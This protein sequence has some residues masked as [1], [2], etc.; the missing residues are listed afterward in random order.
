MTRFPSPRSWGSAVRVYG[1]VGSPLSWIA[2]SGRMS[3]SSVSMGSLRMI[4]GI[5]AG[6][7]YR[8]RSAETAGDVAHELIRARRALPRASDRMLP[9]GPSLKRSLEL[10][11][12]VRTSSL[13]SQCTLDRF[14]HEQGVMMGQIVPKS[15]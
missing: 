5:D 4:G 14:L 11:Y 10:R 9:V 15:R 12:F 3:A 13:T 2:L 1:N 6:R 8:S 7:C